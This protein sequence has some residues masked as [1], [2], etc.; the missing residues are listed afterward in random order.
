MID[1]KQN[2]VIQVIKPATS[3]MIRHTK[4]FKRMDIVRKVKYNYKMKYIILII[5]SIMY[6][7]AHYKTTHCNFIVIG[8][9][10]RYVLTSIVDVES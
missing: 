4:R 6:M 5:G 8:N 1:N 7:L 2:T 3:D 9:V 10:L